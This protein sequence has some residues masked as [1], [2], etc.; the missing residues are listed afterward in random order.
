M[1]ISFSQRYGYKTVKEVIQI[2]SINQDL[3]TGLWNVLTSNYWNVLTSH[4]RIV[5][6]TFL[7]ELVHL[8][9]SDFLKMPIDKIGKYW[10]ES[11]DIIR[12]FFLE[13]GEWYEL[14]D[15]LEFIANNTEFE[16][17][18]NAFMS[19]CNLILERELSGYR[20]INGVITPITSEIEINEI[21]S[22]ISNARF[23]SQHLS[24]ALELLAKKSNPDYRNSIK[25][26]IS[27]VE[28]IS[29][30]LAGQRNGELKNALNVL[31]TKLGVKLHGALKEG[32]LKI[33]GYTSDDNG[34]RHGLTEEG[35]L[36][37]EDAKFML[38]ACSAFVNYL[39]LKSEKAGIEL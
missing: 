22:A 16:D 37:F 32:F 31:E 2:E 24:T 7:C 26:S 29:K 3:K 18:S 6:N 12:D 10:G 1:N 23:G 25:E 33:Y 5:E 17:I 38:V 15:F 39:V 4:R 35:N 19:D 9:W 21:E 11:L 14:Y 36:D 34:I 27:A 30:Q 20:F 8:I 28:S 13:F